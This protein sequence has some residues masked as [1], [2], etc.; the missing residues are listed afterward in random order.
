MLAFAVI[1]MLAFSGCTKE[2]T[3]SV[4]TDD[5]ADALGY[6]LEGNTAGINSQVE[7]AVITYEMAASGKSTLNYCNV[8]FDSSVT[9][10]GTFGQ[11][12]YNYLFN[13]DYELTCNNFNIPQ[14]FTFNYDAQGTYDTPRMS[15]NDSADAGFTLENLTGGSYYLFNGSYVRQGSQQSKVRNQRS[16]NSTIELTL[17]NVSIDKNTYEI[18]GGTAILVISGEGSDGNDFY[19]EGQIDFGVSTATATINGE[20]YDYIL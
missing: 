2:E 5:V 4:T 18:T 14:Y 17:N 12:Q 8:P 3:S 11:K 19:Y 1:G 13:W 15:S 6:A 7:D 20:E 16:F 9:K 10:A